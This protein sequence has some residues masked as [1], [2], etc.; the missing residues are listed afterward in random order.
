[1]R[2]RLEILEG[3]GADTLVRAV[4]YSYNVALEGVGNIFRYD[5]PHK[6]HRPH[7]HVHRYDVMS[8]D[9]RGRVEMIFDE[10]ARPTLGEVLLEA[11]SWYYEHYDAL[12]Q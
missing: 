12:T 5:S 8:G 2:K 6:D 3:V 11:E 9:R 1:M 7:H 4:Y 10:S